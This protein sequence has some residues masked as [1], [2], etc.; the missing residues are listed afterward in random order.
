M[1]DKLEAFVLIAIM[2]CLAAIFVA[3]VIGLVLIADM[4]VH[5]VEHFH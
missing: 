1:S 5:A 3:P 2:I 4:I